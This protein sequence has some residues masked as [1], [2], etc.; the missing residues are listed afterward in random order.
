MKS[1]YPTTARSGATSRTVRTLAKPS[2][3]AVFRQTV[4]EALS[5]ADGD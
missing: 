3:L 5:G 1:S 4:E 2:D